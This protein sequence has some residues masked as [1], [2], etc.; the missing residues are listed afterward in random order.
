M[1]AR[2]AIDDLTREAPVVLTLTAQMPP[3]SIAVEP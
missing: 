2:R 3:A 1:Q